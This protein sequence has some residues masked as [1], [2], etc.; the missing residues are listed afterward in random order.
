[1]VVGIYDRMEFPERLARLI[2]LVGVTQ[3][4]LARASGVRQTYISKLC[5]GTSRPY[6]D[7]A[8]ALARGL[9]V[10]VA[11]LC[12]PDAVIPSSL[13]ELRAIALVDGLVR[14]LDASTASRR[15]MSLPEP[16]GPARTLSIVDESRGLVPVRNDG[17]PVA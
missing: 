14:S 17:E 13:E 6:L 15:L 4:R 7:Q 16:V 5:A 3:T 8:V 12:D 9:G 10:P 11:L 1:M 2:D